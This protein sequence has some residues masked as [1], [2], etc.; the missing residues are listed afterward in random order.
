MN[1]TEQKK[2]DWIA[3]A[4]TKVLKRIINN[5]TGNDSP[6][7]D[8]P[9]AGIRSY[10]WCGPDSGP[11]TQDRTERTTGCLTIRLQDS[12]WKIWSIRSAT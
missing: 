1:K 12:R 2:Q 3:A 6:T 11:S 10:R 4:P 5:Y 9:M 7:H 8:N